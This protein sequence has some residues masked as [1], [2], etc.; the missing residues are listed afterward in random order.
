[1]LA[2]DAV[3]QGDVQADGLILLSSCRVALDEWEQA[4]VSIDGL[5]ILL[6]H[7]HQDANISFEAGRELA[8]Y[9]RGRG[10]MVE[11]VEFEGGHETPLAVWRAVRRLILR[12]LEVC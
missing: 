5:P 9:L 6:S 12:E 1:M 4:S 2:C 10:A 8:D 3:L 11:W 7:G